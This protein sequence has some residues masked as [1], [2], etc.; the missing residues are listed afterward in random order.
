MRVWL[1]VCVPVSMRVYLFVCLSLCLSVGRSP[2]SVGLSVRA[3][4]SVCVRLFVS[5]CIYLYISVRSVCVCRP[6]SIYLSASVYTHLSASAYQHLS[7][8]AAKL[9]CATFY[10]LGAAPSK[11]RDHNRRGISKTE[12]WTRGASIVSSFCHAFFKAPI[13]YPKK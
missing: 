9:F 11:A 13:G 4:L 10:F 8:S 6:A 2:Q 12:L 3:R 1:S 7:M 5:I